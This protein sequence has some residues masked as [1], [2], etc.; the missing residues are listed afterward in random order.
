MVSAAESSRLFTLFSE[1]ANKIDVVL[2]EKRDI[3]TA[4]TLI[5][6]LQST[7]SSYGAVLPP[8]DLKTYGERIE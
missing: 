7:V 8:R 6:E 1:Q 3:D 4:R 2:N 5:Q